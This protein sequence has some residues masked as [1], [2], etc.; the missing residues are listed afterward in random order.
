M[1][2]GTICTACFVAVIIL[3][4]GFVALGVLVIPVLPYFQLDVVLSPKE[5]ADPGV[6]NTTLTLLKRATGNQ[7]LVWTTAGAVLCII[8]AI[9]IRALSRMGAWQRN[10]A[11]SNELPPTSAAR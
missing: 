4:V 10:G 6:R 5:L 9:G 1:R 3:G 2:P 11:A 8:G 7:W